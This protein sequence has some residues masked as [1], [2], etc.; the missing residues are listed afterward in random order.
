MKKSIIAATWLATALGI[1]PLSAHAAVI[2]YDSWTTNEGNSGNYILTVDDNTAG[3]FNVNL[4]VNPWN[5]EALGLFIDFGN[6]DV[7]A[8]GLSSVNPA[9]QV[10]L[11]DTD[12][13]SD[14]CGGGCNL[15]GLA[16]PVDNPDG[17]WELVFRLGSQGFDNIQT[18]SFSINDFGLSL[19][20]WG[21]VGIRAQ[22]LC[23]GND[24]LPGENGDAEECN[25][26]DKS[27]GSS[28]PTHQVPEPGALALFGVGLLGLFASRRRRIS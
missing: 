12:T 21:L 27:Y 10:S 9:G 26:S 22:Q 8:V 2:T 20:D 1:A 18:F 14:S 17:E 19:S 4:T 24:L 6:V 15:N 25:G 13:T 5:A 28:T 11:F 7:G 16:P 23:N 3:S